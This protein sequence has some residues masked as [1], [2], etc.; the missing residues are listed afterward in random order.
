METSELILVL[1]Q[2]AAMARGS[3]DA[4]V[5]RFW[6]SVAV[7]V[8]DQTAPGE[9]KAM[10]K[11]A[12]WVFNLDPKTYRAHLRKA[13]G[14]M[15]S[16]DQSKWLGI[17]RLALNESQ[18]RGIVSPEKADALRAANNEIEKGLGG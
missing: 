6:L 13:L 12:V 11:R 8:A 9:R 7:A 1:E 2:L 10:R 3:E 14:R 5:E 17:I 18:K 15:S 4:D 16:E